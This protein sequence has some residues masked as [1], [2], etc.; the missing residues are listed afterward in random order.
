[1]S[2]FKT[3]W[4]ISIS[5]RYT[6]SV[7]RLFVGAKTQHIE[8]CVFVKKLKIEDSKLAPTQTNEKEYGNLFTYYFW[9]QFEQ[10]LLTYSPEV[11]PFPTGTVQVVNI[12]RKLKILNNLLK[13]CPTLFQPPKVHKKTP[14]I[15]VLYVGDDLLSLKEV[16]SARRGLTSVFGM[17]TGVPLLL[18]HQHTKLIWVSGVFLSYDWVAKRFYQ[19]LWNNCHFQRNGWSG[20]EDSNLHHNSLKLLAP[21]TRWP[22]HSIWYY[23][24][25]T[26][27]L[28]T[29]PK[30]V[31][32]KHS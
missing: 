8:C 15:S 32:Q 30:I 25:S 7:R 9:V 21:A 29:L 4:E 27:T 28:Y 31:S 1:M 19:I 18:N 2:L 24:I 12:F 16:P 26:T 20:L 13:Q 22:F 5:K 23:Y 14:E 3:F 10:A 6:A 17:R 11:D